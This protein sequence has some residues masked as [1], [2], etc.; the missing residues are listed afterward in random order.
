M[1][2]K[3]CTLQTKI[4]KTMDQ[5]I[6]KAA[7][8]SEKQKSAYV[9]A[10]IEFYNSFDPFFMRHM[11]SVAE[12]MNQPPAIVIQNFLTVYI[13]TESAALEAY[14]TTPTIYKRAFQYSKTGEL[15]TGNDLSNLAFDQATESLK[16]LKEK[17]EE[18]ARTGKAAKITFEEAAFI[19]DHR[20]PAQSV[21]LL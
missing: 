1:E 17:L 20:R 2:A 3:T 7:K 14:G 21:G 6:N 12:K 8:L 18:S 4:T 13:A 16:E 9:R 19:A 10:A 5:A 15:I 11:K